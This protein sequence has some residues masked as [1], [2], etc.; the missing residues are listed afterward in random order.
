MCGE[1]SKQ[2]NAIIAARYVNAWQL[3]EPAFK[4][5]REGRVKKGEGENGLQATAITRLKARAQTLPFFRRLLTLLNRLELAHSAA[6][7]A[8]L[9]PQIYIIS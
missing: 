1:G 8:A 6:A 4:V 5:E 9:P 7:R 3:R 2:T